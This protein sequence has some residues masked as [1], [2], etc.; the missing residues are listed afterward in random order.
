RLVAIMFG[1]LRMNVDEA[2]EELLNITDLLYFDES[3]GGIDREKNSTILRQ[4]LEDMLQARG[5]GPETKMNG[6]SSSTQTS[7]IA[8]FAAASTNV[9]HPHVFRTY[10]FRGSPLTPT[11]VE[12]LCATMAIQSHFLPVKLGSRRAQE[13]FIGGALG[14]NNPTRLLLEE[15]GKVFGKE[16]RVAQI[17]SLGCGLPRVLSV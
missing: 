9:T 3:T 5:V 4:A 2:I 17:I 11:I 15:A 12:A 16:R 7:K 10:P 14:A 6:P 13:S 1:H 8:L